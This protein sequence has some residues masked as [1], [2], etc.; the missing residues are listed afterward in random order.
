MEP[1]RLI[2]TSRVITCAAGDRIVGQDPA[3]QSHGL[4]R[5]SCFSLARIAGLKLAEQDRADR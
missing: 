4:R 2:E 5:A 1:Q 3:E